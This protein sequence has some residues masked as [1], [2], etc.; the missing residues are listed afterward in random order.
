[1]YE[2]TTRVYL[3]KD[4]LA[5]EEGPAGRILYAVPGDRV[6]DTEARR[7]G[8][9]QEKKQRLPAKTKERRLEATKR[10][11]KRVVAKSAPRKVV[12]KAVKKAAKKRG[13]K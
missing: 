8:L 11:A 7:I 5:V 3:D 13:K 2:V 9:L 10:P 12:K 6:S 1:V 4:G